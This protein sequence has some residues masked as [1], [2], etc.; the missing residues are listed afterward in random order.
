MNTP[1]IFDGR[2]IYDPI[3]LRRLGFEY[4]C[5]GRATAAQK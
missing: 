2:N 3:K 4:H 5:I 1:M